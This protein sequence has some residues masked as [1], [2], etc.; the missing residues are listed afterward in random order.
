MTDRIAVTI[1]QGVADVRM[2]RADKMNAID[3][4]MFDALADTGT[5]LAKDNSVRAVVLSGEGRAFCAGLDF[6]SFQKM[7]DGGNTRAGQ[8]TPRTHGIA[9]RAQAAAWAWREMPVPVI[10][11]I[12]GVAFGGGCQI[13]LGADIRLIAPDARM[14]VLEIK[15]GLVPDM[16]GL[17]IMRGILR[18]DVARELTYTGRQVTGQE[19]VDL[20]LATRVEADPHAAAMAMAREIASKNPH[21]IRGSKRLLNMVEDA[22]AAAILMAESVEQELLIGSDNQVEAVKA[23]LG[24]R[25]PDFKDVG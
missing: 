22:D 18:D 7:G 10:A 12:N 6:G 11:A 2:N 20:G 14:S 13:A 15:W 1:D 24:K 9:N 19:A 8:L 4:A 21:A 16:S 23:G 17:A 5:E 3:Q 25:A